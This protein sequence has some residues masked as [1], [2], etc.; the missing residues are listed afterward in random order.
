MV[1]AIQPFH[2]PEPEIFPDR[3]RLRIAGQRLTAEHRLTRTN[4]SEYDLQV[5]LRQLQQAFANS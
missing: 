5:C 4:C 1:V 2:H 3:T